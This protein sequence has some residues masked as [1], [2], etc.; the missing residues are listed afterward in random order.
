MANGLLA[1][2]SKSPRG[3]LTP[4]TWDSKDTEPPI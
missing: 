1:M 2:P 4:L 3:F